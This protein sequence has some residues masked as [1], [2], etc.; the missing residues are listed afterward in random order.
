MKHFVSITLFAILLC[1]YMSTVQYNIV[2]VHALQGR[3]DDNNNNNNNKSQGPITSNQ[4]PKSQT[5]QPTQQRTTQP[6]ISLRGSDNKPPFNNNSTATSPK[7]P[8]S[9]NGFDKDHQYPID[10]RNHTEPYEPKGFGGPNEPKRNET[11]PYV[12]NGDMG[13]PKGP[14]FNQTEPHYPNGFGGSDKPSGTKANRDCK[15]LIESYCADCKE[16]EDK[17]ECFE[18]CFTENEELFDAAGC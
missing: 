2:A 15:N 8:G 14:R 3:G 17:R 13:K 6:P 16:A 12:P 4:S 1:V 10:K 7:G 5:Q 11:R 18:D 9:K